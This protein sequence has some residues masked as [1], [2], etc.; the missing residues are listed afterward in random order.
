M[1]HLGD[2]RAYLLHDGSDDDNF[3]YVLVELYFLSLYRMNGGTPELLR[4]VRADNTAG[5][6]TITAYFDGET[7]GITLHKYI[8]PL[9]TSEPSL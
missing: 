1:G 9:E 2:S 6:A 3:Y 8:A 7:S 4:C 5:P